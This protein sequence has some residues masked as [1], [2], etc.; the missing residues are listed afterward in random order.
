VGEVKGEE[1]EV[2][3][4]GE[5]V[6]GGEGKVKGWGGGGKGRRREACY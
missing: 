2:K 3:G 6:K 4:W 5:R 1:G